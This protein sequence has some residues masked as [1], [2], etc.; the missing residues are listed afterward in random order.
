MGGTSPEA[1]QKG[2]LPWLSYF[3]E[4]TS[5]DIDRGSREQTSEGSI[6]CHPSASCFS[7]SK[8]SAAPFTSSKTARSRRARAEAHSTCDPHHTSVSE[9]RLASACRDRGLRNQ[10]RHNRRRIPEFH[11]P[12]RPSLMSDST[13]DAL[14]R[15][16]RVLKR[17]PG[18]PVRRDRSTPSRT[19][20]DNLPFCPLSSRPVTG[21]SRATGRP[22]STINT[23]EPPLRPSIK[24]LKLFLVSVMLAFFHPAKMDPTS[25]PIKAIASLHS[26]PLP[27]GVQGRQHDA[28]PVA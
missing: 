11:R 3:P 22:R 25:T 18:G 7:R 21:S 20:R 24:A 27:A 14:A 19:S 28:D 8:A 5:G 13:A 6:S 15:G 23:G 16:D 2:D 12:S 4:L 9:S 17:A 10:Q 26:T 1:P